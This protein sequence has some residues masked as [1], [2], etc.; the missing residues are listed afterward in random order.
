MGTCSRASSKIAE[1]P[2]NGGTGVAKLH[3]MLP[4]VLRIY[5][6]ARSASRHCLMECVVALGGRLY[7]A[8]TCSWLVATLQPH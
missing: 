2:C 5:I 3:L 1:A 4:K 8:S 7:G 6:V